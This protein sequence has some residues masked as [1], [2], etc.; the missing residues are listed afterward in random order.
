MKK[1][2][3]FLKKLWDHR[4]PAHEF[5][6]EG[7]DRFWETVQMVFEEYQDDLPV[8][9]TMVDDDGEKQHYQ[10]SLDVA[11]ERIY[12]LSKRVYQFESFIREYQSNPDSVEL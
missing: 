9:A 6:S 8:K 2:I 11:A 1:D 4:N 5:D 7:N 10:M 12:S 3:E